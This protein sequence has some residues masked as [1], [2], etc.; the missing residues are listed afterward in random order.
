MNQ[1]NLNA[2]RSHLIAKSM[3]FGRFELSSNRV[4]AY[5][6]DGKLTTFSPECMSLVGK[7]FLEKLTDLGLKPRAVGGLTLGADP[8]AYS[9]GRES[10]DAKR[11]ILVFSVR[12]EAKKHG[13]Q[14]RVEGVDKA[15]GMDVVIIDDVC[16]TGASTEDAIKGAQSD[17]MNVLAAICL[18]DRKAGAAE[19]LKDRFGVA[20]Y[21]LFTLPELLDEAERL[22]LYSPEK[23]LA[24]A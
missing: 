13:M 24:H 21:S 16:T 12:K 22:G 18:V 3:K 6:I 11:P 19:L 1:Q 17:G 7:A 9:I 8:I 15:Q 14:R 4:S 2:L 10:F 20:L 23:E 5:Y